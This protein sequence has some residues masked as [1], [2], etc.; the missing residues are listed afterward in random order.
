MSVIKI[1]RTWAINRST[2]IILY[3]EQQFGFLKKVSLK[4]INLQFSPSYRVLLKGSSVTR[5]CSLYD[6][7]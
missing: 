2:S 3:K 6:Y 4:E 1:G 5:F 7:R